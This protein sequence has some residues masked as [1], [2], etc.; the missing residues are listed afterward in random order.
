MPP[1]NP[2]SLSNLLHITWMTSPYPVAW[3]NRLLWVINTLRAQK[4]VIDQKMGVRALQICFSTSGDI[5]RHCQF[6]FLSHVA[7]N[8][9]LE[10]C[11]SQILMDS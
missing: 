11:S 2:S 10:A 5:L 9:L 6:Q 8:N 7:W 1:S 3:P 4:E